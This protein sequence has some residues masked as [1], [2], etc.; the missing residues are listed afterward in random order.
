MNGEFELIAKLRQQLSEFSLRVGAGDDTAVIAR[1]DGSSWLFAT[2]MLLDGVHFR[3]TET[4]PEL[5]GRKALAVNLSDIAAMGGTPTSAVVSVA[6]PRGSDIGE[7]LHQGLIDLAREF[8]VVIAGG[9]TNSWDGPLVINVA[10]TGELAVGVDPLLRSGARVGD[11]ILVTGP[12]GGSI[13][14]HHLNFTPRVRESLAIRDA[15]TVN[16][17]IDVSDGLASDL[18][19]I[20]RESNVGAVLWA[21]RIPKRENIAAQAD[22]LERA[23]GDG[24]DFELLFTMPAANAERLVASPPDGVDL[25]HIGE[26]TASGAELVM[27][28]STRRPL[29]VCGWEH[30][31]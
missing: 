11:W 31:L 14:G 19:H 8:D 25:F 17:M 27:A 23:L 22:G 9:D 5:I 3:L 16:A 6:L 12:C 15:A 4:S 13:D 1:A 28:D 7:P 26:I 18:H 30:E 10:V 2:D 20:L 21:E 29:E 24:E